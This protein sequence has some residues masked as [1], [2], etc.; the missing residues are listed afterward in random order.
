MTPWRQ[1][2]EPLLRPATFKR[3]NVKGKRPK[4]ILTLTS[5]STSKKTIF[6]IPGIGG[7]VLPYRRMAKCLSG[8]YMVKGIFLPHWTDATVNC[9][10]IADFA[11]YFE[12]HLLPDDDGVVRI[13]GYSIGGVIA[14][15]AAIKL[16]NA[17]RRVHLILFD[18]ACW[19]LADS[20][21]TFGTRLD[22]LGKRAEYALNRT[23]YTLSGNQWA[24]A[25][26]ALNAAAL[27]YQP[28]SLDTQLVLI[29]PETVSISKRRSFDAQL[30]WGKVSKSV[31]VIHT[32]GEHGD[33]YRGANGQNFA[34]AMADGFDWLQLQVD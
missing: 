8:T 5:T 31:K 34:R 9:R 24:Y 28:R 18:T 2:L 32:P 6:I 30:G 27:N 11:A 13:L 19:A 21:Q 14:F 23:K 16:M 26:A 1:H 15:E 20:V 3:S 12:A 25:K 33:A 10:T 7:H 4:P 29:K 22:T 17:G